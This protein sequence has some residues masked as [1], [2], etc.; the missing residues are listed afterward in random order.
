MTLASG[1]KVTGTAN[2]PFLTLAGWTALGDLEVG[3]QIVAPR[4]IPS[5]ANGMADMTSS[6]LTLLGHMI[7]DGCHLSTHALQYTTVDLI[8]ADIVARAAK[9]AFDIEA[10]VTKERS[11]YQV[12]LPAP[13]HLTHGRRNPLAEW[14]DELGLF[15]RRSHEKFVPDAVFGGTTDQIGL[16]LR[17]LWATDGLSGRRTNLGTSTTPPAAVDWLTTFRA[18]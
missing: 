11:W 15:D 4:R 8:N 18:C 10:R 3:D 6:H 13:H 5:R 17:H 12:Y 16:F 9:E 2:H 1:R 7:G 14:L